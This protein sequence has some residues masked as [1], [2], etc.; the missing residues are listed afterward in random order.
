MHQ[1]KNSDCQRGSKNTAQLYAIY[2]KPA[3]NTKKIR[4]KVNEQRDFPGGPLAKMGP[5]FHPR[6]GNQI[7][8]VTTSLRAATKDPACHNKDLVQPNKQ[9]STIPS[10]PAVCDP[11]NCSPPGFCPWN[12]PG[13]NTGIGCH[14]L[15]QG[16]FLT[17]GSKLQLLLCLLHS[18]LSHQ[19]SLEVGGG[20]LKPVFKYIFQLVT[21]SRQIQKH[22]HFT[23]RGT[24]TKS[25]NLYFKRAY[26][27]FDRY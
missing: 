3:F 2:R 10:C 16:I 17:Q 1:L 4:L 5:G 11:M 9:S 12:F 20:T 6:S 13:K 26:T 14:F 22:S 25:P 24:E 27:I 7:P 19:G 18:R 21:T 15:L 23:D 8:Y